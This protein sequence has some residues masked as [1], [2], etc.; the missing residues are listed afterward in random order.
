M[1]DQER[2][3]WRAL[4][5]CHAQ[6]NLERLALSAKLSIGQ[7]EQTLSGLIDQGRVL[8]KTRANGRVVYQAVAPKR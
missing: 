6:G 5:R 4:K 7:V 3:V 1:T 2:A 8:K